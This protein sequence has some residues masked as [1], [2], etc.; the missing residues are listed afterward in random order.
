MLL[1]IEKSLEPA[2]ATACQAPIPQLRAITHLLQSH[3]DSNH[4]VV[5][6]PSICR[7]WEDCGRLSEE[8][9]GIAKKIRARY[10][11]LAALQS[12]VPV[13]GLISDSGTHPVKVNN[14]WSIPLQWIAAHGLSSTHL[15][16]EDLY[17]CS[18]FKEAARDYLGVNS[19]DRLSLAIENIPGGGGNT[20]RLLSDK[21]ITN[22]RV[23]V[24]IVDSD[25]DEPS[26]TSAFG[27]TA[28]KC[29][30]VSGPGLYE[31][32]TTPGRELEN[33]LPARLI[34]KIR[35]LWDGLPPSQRRSQLSAIS[36]DIP[37]FADYKS[38]LKLREFD[39]FKGPSSN[40]WSSVLPQLAT[41][42]KNC[43]PV[44]CTATTNGGC[45]TTV[46]HPLGNALLKDACAYL[47][48]NS[49]DRARHKKYLPSQ[50]DEGWLAMGAIV[51][52]YGLSV[53]IAATI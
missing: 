43:C 8:Q 35:Q 2:I 20:H 30:S 37:V 29:L 28:A 9:R 12:I 21:A 6:P 25:R 22:Q 11:E 41:G 27:A 46:I 13:Y 49:S 38:G 32:S 15:V 19:L 53:K 14:F 50:G 48:Q 4:I 51:A 7:I 33:H 31:V 24:C 44:G 34:D 26:G 1:V 40:F 5:A 39:H 17:D 36:P 52:S 47:Q 45:K 16:C 10:S 3:A 23:T 18:L 42:L